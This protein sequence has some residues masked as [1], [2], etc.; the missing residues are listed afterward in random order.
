[1]RKIKPN[2]GARFR[3]KAKFGIAAFWASIGASATILCLINLTGVIIPRWILYE[4]LVMSTGIGLMIG[5]RHGRSKFLPDSFVDEIGLDVPYRAD[6][7]TAKN[8]REACEMTVPYYRHEYV[9]HDIAE[10]WRVKNPK[11][12][13][14][15]V[16]RDNVLCASFGIL[17]LKQNFMELF[18]AGTVSDTQLRADHVCGLSESKRSDNLYIS[19]VIVRDSSTYKGQKRATVMIWAM[20]KYIAYLYGF[21]KD[22]DLYALAVTKESERVLEHLNFKCHGQASYRVDKCKLYHYRLSKESWGK[23]LNE[24]GDYARMC[25][26]NF[27]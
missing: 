19:G 2:V 15:I 6:F 11:V 26:C 20:L 16:N 9:S 25:V 22:R 13:V 17:A 4:C 24:V 3:D 1:V 5:L 10:Q 12:F 7:C 18:I 14:Q 23:L 8:L 27:K 21:K